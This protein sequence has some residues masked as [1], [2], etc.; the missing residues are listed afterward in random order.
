MLLPFSC[1]LC[2]FTVS[3]L[4]IKL[5]QV[6]T[7]VWLQIL[8]HLAAF[9]SRAFL[10]LILAFSTPPLFFLFSMFQTVNTA[11]HPQPTEHRWYMLHRYRTELLTVCKDM[12]RQVTVCPQKK[13][14]K[15]TNSLLVE[16]VWPR[17]S[18]C[19][20]RGQLSAMTEHRPQKINT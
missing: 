4:I 9:A 11:E 2:V 12:L 16:G 8:S 5:K 17:N 7:M 1:G 14:R 10:F 20:L 19:R 6:R 18:S 15:K 13:N 3:L